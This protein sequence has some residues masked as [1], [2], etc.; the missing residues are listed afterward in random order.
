MSEG[1]PL[2]LPTLDELRTGL[3][4]DFP[5]SYLNRLAKLL[6]TEPENGLTGKTLAQH[7]DACLKEFGKDQPVELRT[8]HVH[9]RDALV[10]LMRRLSKAKKATPAKGKREVAADEVAIPEPEAQASD[11]ETEPSAG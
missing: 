5:N 4:G 8:R 10:A 1:V 6:V 2:D 9:D 3:R 11:Q 7:V